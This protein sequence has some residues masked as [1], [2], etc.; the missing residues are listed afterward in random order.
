MTI[1]HHMRIKLNLPL[2]LCRRRETEFI[3]KFIIVNIKHTRRCSLRN[4]D[5]LV[6]SLTCLYDY[7]SGHHCKACCCG[8]CTLRRSLSWLGW[9]REFAVWRM[10][11]KALRANCSTL[12]PSSTRL[13]RHPMRTSGTPLF[14][15]N[16][17][18]RMCLYVHGDA[19]C[20]YTAPQ[21]RRQFCWVMTFL[22]RTKS[23]IV[24]SMSIT[25]LKFLCYSICYRV[26]SKFR[27]VAIGLYD[28]LS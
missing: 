21:M 20:R 23:R 18:R 28:V 19:D 15:L 24:T 8:L 25:W 12:R 5:A 14:H 26:Y 22:M 9:R 3:V 11:S 7:S 4:Q 2:T 13:P 6:Y 16:Y 17:H 1:L 10:T 27:Y